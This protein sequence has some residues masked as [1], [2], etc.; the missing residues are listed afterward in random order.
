MK[1]KLANIQ[2]NSLLQTNALLITIN[3]FPKQRVDIVGNMDVIDVPD[4][5]FFLCYI[6]PQSKFATITVNEVG[7]LVLHDNVP[8]EE[9]TML[10]S[11]ISAF[12]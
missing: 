7:Q 4:T 8:I 1:L 9:V 11:T 10:V 3:D 12:C 6:D 2:V 5:N